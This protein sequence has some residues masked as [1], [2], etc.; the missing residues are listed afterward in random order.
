MTNETLTTPAAP[1]PARIPLTEETSATNR[2]LSA[3]ELDSVLASWKAVDPETDDSSTHSIE[4]ATEIG[5]ENLR[6]ASDRIKRRQQKR[7]FLPVSGNERYRMLAKYDGFIL[8]RDNESFVARLYEN[9][10]DYPIM[11]AEFGIEDISQSEREL[12]IPGAPLVWTMSY[13]HEGSTVFRDS[14]IYLRRMEWNSADVAAARETV[15]PLTDGL[16]W[17]PHSAAQ[18]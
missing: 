16:D 4:E 13:R 3:S 2:F 6:D 15:A 17:E 10:S 8:S 9:G 11:E 5:S 7:V 12:A 18:Q 1:R 14:R